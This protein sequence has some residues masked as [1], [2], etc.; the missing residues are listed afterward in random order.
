MILYLDS[1]ALVKLYVREDRSADVMHWRD[2]AEAVATS[3]VAYAEA[4][5]AFARL[6]REGHSKSTSHAKR[7]AKFNQDWEDYIRVELSPALTRQAG[8]LA[9]IYALRGFDAI[10]LASAFWLK[11]LAAGPAHFAAFD[12]RLTEAAVR[13]GLDVI[14]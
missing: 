5:A 1:S 13:A 9:E 14:S 12:Q 6:V 8:D 3:V 11:E 10:H 7:L 4:R 2:A